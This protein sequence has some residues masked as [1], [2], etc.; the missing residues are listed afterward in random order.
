MN[1]GYESLEV[2][3][4]LPTDSIR[5]PLTMNFP[6]GQQVGI[7]KPKIPVEI[8]FQ[9]NKPISF[10]AKLEFLDNDTGSY[11]LPISGTTENCILTCHSYLHHNADYYTLEGNP[12]QLREKEADRDGGGG[13]GAAR[14]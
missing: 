3:F 14:S 8:F 2:K 11:T 10:C 1:E 7:T 9:S 5:I 12:V 4:R 13:E 6:E